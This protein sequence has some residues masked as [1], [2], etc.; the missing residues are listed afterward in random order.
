M[1]VGSVC[2][3]ADRVTG[4][5]PAQLGA[6]DVRTTTEGSRLH[7]GARATRGGIRTAAAGNE[8]PGCGGIQPGQDQTGDRRT[9]SKQCAYIYTYMELS[10]D[11]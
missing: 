3:G 9:G 5:T 2:A 4:A 6:D 1:N 7:D 10:T 8:D 11:S